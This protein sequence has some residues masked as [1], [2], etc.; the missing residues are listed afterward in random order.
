M[1]T[2]IYLPIRN[3]LNPGEDREPYPFPQDEREELLN[4]LWKTRT[5]LPGSRT[6]P[7]EQLRDYVQAQEEKQGSGHYEKVAPARGVEPLSP[8]RLAQVRGFL[9]ER[10]IWQRKRLQAAGLL[11]RRD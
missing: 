8:D 9:K 3:W 10:A 2:K 7:V 1:G 5:L 6:M 11:P 4:R